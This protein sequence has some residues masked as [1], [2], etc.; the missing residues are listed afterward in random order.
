MF[1]RLK[2]K[3][4]AWEQ[5]ASKQQWLA[6]Q[7]APNSNPEATAKPLSEPTPVQ[8]MELDVPET[9]GETPNVPTTPITPERLCQAADLESIS[10]D[11][12]LASPGRTLEGLPKTEYEKA[13]FTPV[14]SPDRS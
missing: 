12:W 3:R 8:S 1:L 5:M 13:F 10:E 7:P 11:A 2:E 4:R 9:K 6:K 14:G